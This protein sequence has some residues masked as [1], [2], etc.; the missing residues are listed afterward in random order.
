ME[1][2]TKC[3]LLR[4]SKAAF[5]SVGRLMDQYL[6]EPTVLPAA[7]EKHQRPRNLR[8]SHCAAV[9]LQLST[10]GQDTSALTRAAQVP[11]QSWPGYFGPH[12]SGPSSSAAI[13]LLLLSGS[14]PQTRNEKLP[15]HRGRA[16]H[17]RRGTGTAPAIAEGAKLQPGGIGKWVCGIAGQGID[18]PLLGAADISATDATAELQTTASF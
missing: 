13:Q 7:L 16:P 1:C 2:S 9:R 15:P 17:R 11:V 6:L 8:K 14:P 10:C 3:V 12:P 4:R 18:G 5:T